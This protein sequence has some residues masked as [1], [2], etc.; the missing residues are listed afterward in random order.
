AK[1]GKNA[2]QILEAFYPQMEIEIA[3]APLLGSPSG[4][5]SAV[6]RYS[7]RHLKDS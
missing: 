6:S 5:L 1:Q 2:A 4:N 7:Q 3:G